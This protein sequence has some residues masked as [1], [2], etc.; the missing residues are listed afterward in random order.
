MIR[1]W[2]SI[3]PSMCNAVLHWHRTVLLPWILLVGVK[4]SAFDFHLFRIFEWT[5]ESAVGGTYVVFADVWINVQFI[6]ANGALEWIVESTLFNPRR[7]PCG[8][9]LFARATCTGRCHNQ[10]KFLRYQHT[11]FH[12]CFSS[13]I[14]RMRFLF[15]SVL[16]SGKN[17]F[18]SV[19]SSVAQIWQL[20]LTLVYRLSHSHFNQKNCNVSIFRFFNNNQKLS[21]KNTF[22]QIF[23]PFSTLFNSIALI[24]WSKRITDLRK[25]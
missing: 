2:F 19:N 6:D 14:I 23:L 3:A 15:L 9:S 25:R 8:H 20:A 16:W 21:T 11:R 10:R 24:W 13:F 18:A 17:W 1:L 12:D 5:I 22:I 7:C 4:K